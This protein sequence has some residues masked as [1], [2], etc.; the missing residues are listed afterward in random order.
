MPTIDGINIDLDKD[1]LDVSAIRP[2]I[3]GWFALPEHLVATEVEH[4]SDHL[5]RAVAAADDPLERLDAEV[6]AIEYAVA[7]IAIGY[8]AK[9]ALARHLREHPEELE[10]ERRLFAR[11]RV[12]DAAADVVRALRR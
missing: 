10:E 5:T 3:E 1:M 4:G 2:R 6:A 11:Q 12:A 7:S 8:T 9:R